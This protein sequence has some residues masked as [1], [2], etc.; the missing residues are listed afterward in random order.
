M[1]RDII[2]LNVVVFFLIVNIDND[3]WYIYKI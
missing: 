2:V 3:V 1:G